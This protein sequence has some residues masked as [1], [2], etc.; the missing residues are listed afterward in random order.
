MILSEGRRSCGVCVL[1]RIWSRTGTEGGTK[2]ALLMKKLVPFYGA[3][4]ACCSAGRAQPTHEGHVHVDREVDAADFR[5]T[6]RSHICE[7][8]EIRLCEWR[9]TRRLV[10]DRFY[11]RRTVVTEDGGVDATFEAD[12]ARVG[13][14]TNPVVVDLLC[15]V[16]LKSNKGSA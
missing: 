3:E 15:S 1:L 16:Q 7:R 14:C 12:V 4:S 8:N 6:R 10:G 13:V 11:I 2:L 5:L 9:D